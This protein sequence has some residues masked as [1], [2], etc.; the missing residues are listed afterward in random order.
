MGIWTWVLAPSLTGL[1]EGQWS[2]FRAV[3]PW[4]LSFAASLEPASFARSR[5]AY[6]WTSS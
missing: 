2:V 1:S 6:P 4:T 3:V 5:D